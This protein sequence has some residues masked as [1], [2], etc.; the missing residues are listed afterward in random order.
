MFMKI[1]WKVSKGKRNK[2][3]KKEKKK[4]R[5]KNAETNCT[6][7][8]EIDGPEIEKLEYFCYFIPIIAWIVREISYIII[9]FYFP[10]IKLFHPLYMKNTILLELYHPNGNKSNM[11]FLYFHNVFKHLI[12]FTLFKK[13]AFSSDR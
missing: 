12:H 5:R 2:Q 9:C 4:E 6:L 10:I 11:G 13:H 1:W 3:K 8:L 7:E